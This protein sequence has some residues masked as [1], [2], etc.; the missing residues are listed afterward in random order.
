MCSAQGSVGGS[1]KAQ[2]G[3]A[4][5]LSWLPAC[6]KNCWQWAS[7]PAH[8][9]PER[10][11]DKGV[12]E[13]L[14]TSSQAACGLPELL[15][16]GRLRLLQWQV[17]HEEGGAS[18]PCVI[19]HFPPKA[20][21]PH[22]HTSFRSLLKHAAGVWPTGHH[23]LIESSGLLPTSVAA[24]SM[25]PCPSGLVRSSSSHCPPTCPPSFLAPPALRMAP[26]SLLMTLHFS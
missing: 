7:L 19:C 17:A 2:L 8:A 6:R 26:K 24:P 3:P 13:R 4:P 5:S 1:T 14:G 16:Q 15:I 10:Q 12:E 20:P 25:P 21:R 23:L 11:A 18:P 9:H 22:G